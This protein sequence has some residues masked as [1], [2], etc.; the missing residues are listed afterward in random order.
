MLLDYFVIRF[1]KNCTSINWTPPLF[2][3]LTRRRILFCEN[4]A[5]TQGSY[6][7]SCSLFFLIFLSTIL[8]SLFYVSTLHSIKVLIF[9]YRFVIFSWTIVAYVVRFIYAMLIQY[10]SCWDFLYILYFSLIFKRRFWN[11]NLLCV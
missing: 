4:I 9:S 3:F 7:T 10:R 5:G 11:I 2:F 8:L 1:K 6:I